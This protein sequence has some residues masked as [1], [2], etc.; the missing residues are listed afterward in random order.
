MSCEVFTDDTENMILQGRKISNWG[1]NVYVKV[2]VN[3]S[4]TFMG[5]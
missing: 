4:G 2:P 5:K 3:S 1:K